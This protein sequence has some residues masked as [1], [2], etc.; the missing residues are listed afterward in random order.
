M[1]VIDVACL[2]TY[3]DWWK[4]T[5]SVPIRLKLSFIYKVQSYGYV[6]LTK[7]KEMS[8]FAF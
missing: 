4:G 1:K 5:N 6:T 7:E 8:Q 2:V 3:F